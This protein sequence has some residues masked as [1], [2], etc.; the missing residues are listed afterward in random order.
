M[1]GRVDYKQQPLNI[2]YA[3]QMAKRHLVVFTAIGSPTSDPLRR[4]PI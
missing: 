4:L 3:M 2:E 1:P